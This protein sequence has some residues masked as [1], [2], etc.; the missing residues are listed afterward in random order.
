MS[1]SLLWVNSLA[2]AAG[3]LLYPALSLVLVPFYLRYLGLEGYGLVGFLATLVTLLSVFTKGLGAGLQREF[4]R[5]HQSPAEGE[6]LRVLRTFEL[7]YLGAGL[8]V[9]LFVVLT[10]GWLSRNWVRTDTIEPSTVVWCLWLVA[11]RL[12]LAFPASVYQ[13]ALLGAQRQVLFNSLSAVFS[14]LAA[15]AGVTVVLIWQSVTALYASDVAIH[16]CSVWAMRRYAVGALPAAHAGA[17]VSFDR[18]QVRQFAGL[19]AGLLWT[20]G[21]GLVLTQLDR[22]LLSR[23]QAIAALGIYTAGIAGGRLLSLCYLPFLT[24]V[25]PQTCALAAAGPGP[26]LADHLLRNVRVVAAICLACGLPIA[27]F[28][29]EVLAAWTRNAS[30][31]QGGATVMTVYVLASLCL[32]QATPLWQLQVALG[33]TRHGV[34]FNT[35]AAFW[36]PP[37]LWYLVGLRG[38]DGAALAW[39]VYCVLA[40]V[41]HAGVTATL[42]G[43]R[44][45]LPRYLRVMSGAVLAAVVITGGARYAADLCCQ[46]ALMLRVA[47]AG[48]SGLAVLA[49]LGQSFIAGVLPRRAV[50]PLR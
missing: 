29:G 16:A 10:A 34:V 26:I 21:I 36:Y 22:V 47:L 45:W 4:A 46:G 7:V 25:Y 5:R 39:L 38:L 3:H 48:G 33:D 24:A 19:S 35:L 50:T 15:L 14:L 49:L 8:A 6:P 42:I 28:P 11:L 9:A 41:Y 44:R 31:V 30:V 2:N 37:A 43:D 12:G 17:D 32:A 23:V 27:W 13:S 20:N 40:W 1:L 18:A